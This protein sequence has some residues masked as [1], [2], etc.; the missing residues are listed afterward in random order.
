MELILIRHTTPDIEKGICYGQSDIPLA[1]TFMKELIP[2]LQFIPVDDAS[3]AYYSSPLTRCKTL[4]EQLATDV[5]FDDRI[6]ELDFGDWELK[7]WG[8]LDR[9]EVDTWMNDFVNAPTKNGE[10]YLDLHERTHYFLED[11]KKK[12]HKKAIVVTHGGVIRSITA[13]IKNTSLL[14]SFDTP[15]NYG[16]IVKFTL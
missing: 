10:S 14:N 12:K 3:V 4:A 7:Y 11:L 6:K 5:I 13:H 8:D 2:I 1:D 15:L 9:D 16:S